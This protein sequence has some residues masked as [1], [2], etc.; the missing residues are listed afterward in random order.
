MINP[1]R[2]TGPIYKGDPESGLTFVGRDNTYHDI[3]K[4][5]QQGEYIQIIGP[6]QSGRTTLA[7]DIIDRLIPS[8]DSTPTYIPVLI[9]CDSL[10]DACREGFIR[11]VCT[12]LS[13]VIQQYFQG[14]AYKV[15]R[16]LFDKSPDNLLKFHELL[17]ECGEKIKGISTFVILLDEIEA[18]P[19]NLVVDVLRFF[20]GLFHTYAENRC[21]SPYRV[22]IFTTHD[23][24]YWNLG[25]SSPY[26]MS[27]ILPLKPFSRKELDSMLGKNHVGKLL[28]NI[29]F[30][31]SAKQRIYHESG[32]HPY[33]IQ[34]LCHIIIEQHLSTENEVTLDDKVVYKAV[35]KLFGKGDKKL[36]ILYNEFPGDST[37]WRLCKKLVAGH[38]EPFE[39]D[40][41]DIK[42]LVELGIICDRN[43]Y[44]QISA[45]IY[46][47]QI[48]KRYFHETFLA[49]E[50]YF[51][52]N[53]QL[54]LRISCL[55]EILLNT[56]IGEFVFSK[57]AFLD[58]D[59]YTNLDDAIRNNQEDILKDLNELIIE[60]N[61]RPEE[62][63]IHAF[64]EYYDLKLTV[65]QSEIL[66]LLLRG[67]DVLHKSLNKS[68]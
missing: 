57:L 34:R 63:E 39:A 54:P 21:K 25:R 26:N 49:I 2:Y 13:K 23:L 11:T 42:T 40:R 44:C 51:T 3:Y 36:Q 45:N 46:K 47:R 28:A 19:D 43:H 29:S 16:K 52:E 12:R 24:S 53:E 20:R 18:L 41:P 66:R 9:S 55:Q 37:E 4:L 59:K 64:I 7:V 5:I 65:N 56:E 10:M 31:D 38:C 50:D 35:L 1:F 14:R 68:P 15:L 27:N 62:K 8:D 33:F 48:L 67:F 60:K 22:V 58:R 61:L 32:G 17:A 6:Y 30:D